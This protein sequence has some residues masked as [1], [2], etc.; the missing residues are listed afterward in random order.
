MFQVSKN[1][2]ETILQLLPSFAGEMDATKVYHSINDLGDDIINKRW[3]YPG[4]IVYVF[5]TKKYYIIDLLIN[6][7]SDYSEVI[8]NL[9]LLHLLSI[10]GKKD[11]HSSDYELQGYTNTWVYNDLFQNQLNIP[12]TNGQTI[13][14]NN[15]TVNWIQSELRFTNDISAVGGTIVATLPLMPNQGFNLFLMSIGDNSGTYCNYSS[16]IFVNRENFT[17]FAI[18]N[19]HLDLTFNTFS[20]DLTNQWFI[21]LQKNNPNIIINNTVMKIQLLNF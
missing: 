2:K 14:S 7:Q 3:I 17:E 18:Q 9:W 19:T 15:G 16:Q 4:K 6:G 5:E 20:D 13:I 1:I 21:T 12:S 11:F 10:Q 8:K